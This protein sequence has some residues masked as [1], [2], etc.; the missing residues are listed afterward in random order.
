MHKFLFHILAGNQQNGK[1]GFKRIREKARYP[2]LVN[3]INT[4]MANLDPLKIVN[5]QRGNE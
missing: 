3:K 1:L 5:L 2:L 4:E